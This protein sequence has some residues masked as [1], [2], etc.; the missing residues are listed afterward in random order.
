MFTEGIDVKKSSLFKVWFSASC[1]L[2]FLLCLYPAYIF[3]EWREDQKLLEVFLDMQDQR[4]IELLELVGCKLR[5]A[6]A[7]A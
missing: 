4:E 7:R 3:W 2:V 6:S 5:T 1:T